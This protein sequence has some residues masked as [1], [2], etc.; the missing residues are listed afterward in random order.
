[1]SNGAQQTFG[2]SCLNIRLN[3]QSAQRQRKPLDDI[4]D[5][6]ECVLGAPAIQ[7]ALTNLMEIKPGSSLDRNISVL[8]CL[9]CKTSVFY[10]KTQQQPSKSLPSPSSTVYLSTETK[11]PSAVKEGERSPQYSA[12]FGIILLPSIVNSVKPRPTTHM[13]VD[14][15][16]KAL[17]FL[18]KEEDKKNERIKEY[19]KAQNAEYE[20]LRQNTN[21]QCSVIAEIINSV[22]PQSPSS[23]PHRGSVGSS[24]L[25]SMLKPSIGGSS[26]NRGAIPFTRPAG[27]ARGRSGYNNG[28]SDEDLDDLNENDLYGLEDEFDSRVSFNASHGAPSNGAAGRRGG[29]FPSSS[30][31]SGA[32]SED[33]EHEEN[34]FG[35]FEDNNPL[36]GFHAYDVDSAVNMPQQDIGLSSGYISSMM[37]GSLPQKIPAF[38]SIGSSS[39]AG[40]PS[41]SRLESQKKADEEMTRRRNEA[42]KGIPKT[43]V[44][45]HE[46]LDKMHDAQDQDWVIGSK[47]RESY[48]WNRKYAPG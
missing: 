32:N 17:E 48:G 39:Y 45:P 29:G 20:R 47:P 9:L 14:I 34:E 18:E 24:G 33:F 25:A 38:G 30:R 31:Q 43:F 21:S 23:M 37:P 41:L 1:M 5:V 44:P 13:S 3:V 26:D 27:A 35:R 46:L 22:N 15:R 2:C 11:G 16:Q 12:L 4:R 28:N 10:F 36:Q 40:G 8:R 6:L 42:L 19:I 7:V